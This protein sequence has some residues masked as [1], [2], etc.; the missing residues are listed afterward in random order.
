MGCVSGLVVKA[1]S[2]VC[3][4]RNGVTRAAWVIVKSAAFG[5]TAADGF[6]SGLGCLN[7]TILPQDR[8]R[9]QNSRDTLDPSPVIYV[10]K[11][12]LPICFCV[13]YYC[14]RDIILAFIFCIPA[15]KFV[16]LKIPVNQYIL[17]PSCLMTKCSDVVDFLK[18]IFLSESW[19][20]HELY[21]K[22]NFSIFPESC[23][24]TG[25]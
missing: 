11:C 14:R 21:S 7:P 9:C 1:I 15:S 5:S 6:P 19:E 23:S 25:N 22:Q 12:E 18:K 10:L 8:Y 3:H 17:L 20:N 24:S 13:S 2:P 16:T 4:P